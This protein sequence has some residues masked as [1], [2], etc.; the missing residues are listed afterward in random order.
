MIGEIESYNKDTQTGVIKNEE[1]FFEFHINE[2]R[3][4][5]GPYVG[6]DVLFEGKEGEATLVTLIGNYV[7]Q[8]E[9][10]KSR[11]IA[12]LLGLFLGWVG[13]HRFYLGYY[14]LAVIQII[15]TVV[16][17]GFGALWGFIDTFL[18]YSGQMNEDAKGRPLK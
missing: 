14:R 9:P 6:D 13:A 8:Q 7:H 2:W 11:R 3:E 17:L 4:N 18:L 5:E 16:T 10:V 15:V 12:T 1:G